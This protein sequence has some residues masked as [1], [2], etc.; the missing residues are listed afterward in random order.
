MEHRAFDTVFFLRIRKFK[1][2]KALKGNVFEPPK[3]YAHC[4]RRQKVRAH[5]VRILFLFFAFHLAQAR[6]DCCVLAVQKTFFLLKEL[7]SVFSYDFFTVCADFLSA[8]LFR[9]GVQ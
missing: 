4:V 9:S 7:R 6:S 5:I 3:R 2:S 8:A 1:Y